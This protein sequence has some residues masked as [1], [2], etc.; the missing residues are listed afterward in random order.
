MISGPN[1]LPED[2]GHYARVTSPRKS[3]NALCASAGVVE[4]S[5]K[6]RAARKSVPPRVARIIHAPI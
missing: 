6:R 5:A 2:E 1:K 4:I 3:G